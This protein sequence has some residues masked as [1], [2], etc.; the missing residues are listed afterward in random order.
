MI[1]ILVDYKYVCYIKMI[2]LL[3]LTQAFQKLYKT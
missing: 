2:F 1:W 3:F